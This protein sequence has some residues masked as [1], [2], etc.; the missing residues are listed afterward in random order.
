MLSS[1]SAQGLT[2]EMMIAVTEMCHH[3][4][5]CVITIIC[6]YWSVY[7]VLA[8]NMDIYC[9]HDRLYSVSYWES[10]Y[11][12]WT[13]GTA[14]QCWDLEWNSSL[15]KGQG[16]LIHFCSC[17]FYYC[18]SSHP[19]YTICIFPSNSFSKKTFFKFWIITLYISTDSYNLLSLII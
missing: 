1:H 9:Q 12:N 5:Q 14:L 10:I 19:G 4:W 2:H 13:V 7:L 18:H 3:L 11:L 16:N 8:V 6:W 15:L 17:L